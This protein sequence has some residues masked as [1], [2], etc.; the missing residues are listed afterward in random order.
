M[1]DEKLEPEDV[2]EFDELWDDSDP[3]DITDTTP[4]ASDP[5]PAPAANQA[6]E[7]VAEKEPEPAPP[8]DTGDDEDT[9][10]H[11]LA[12][13][14]GRF[15]VF[16]DSL[17]D[18]RTKL[19]SLEASKQVEPE[20]EPEPVKPALP[21]GWTQEDWDDYRSDN[22]VGA[23]LF[24]TQNREVEQLKET[25]NQN[26]QQQQ[27][28]KAQREFNSTVMTA[29]P[30]YLELLDNKRQDILSFIEAEPNPLLQQAYKGVYQQGT[31]EQVSELMTAYKANRGNDS[32]PNLQQRRVQDALAVPN[33]SGNPNS[34][35]GKNGLPG[36]DDFDSAWIIL[37]MMLSTKE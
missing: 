35:M 33:R 12:S 7:S 25:V 24:E 34:K 2:T 13:A 9:L 11:K 14:E 3:D 37:Q 17:E 19:A 29:H 28:D 1:N 4:V 10:R 22:P 32:A 20:P 30:D 18:M 21:E 8:A 26:T 36:E 31:A 5:E 16:Q 27:M 23:E 6:P 15:S